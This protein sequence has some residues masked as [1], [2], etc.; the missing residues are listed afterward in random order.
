MRD[1]TLAFAGML[2][3]GELVRQIASSG[4]YSRQAAEA[5]LESIFA[6]DANSAEA[7]YG[8]LAG[9]RMGLQ[10]V[11]QLFSDQRQQEHMPA[12]GY[13]VGLSRIE[14]ELRAQPARLQAMG[15]A[16]DLVEPVRRQAES[17]L[18]DS[19]VA[20]LADV[21]RQHVSVLKF[22]LAIK[23]RAEY[24]QRSDKAALVRALLLA[25]LRSAVLWQQTGGRRWRLV[26]Q[27]RKMLNEAQALLKG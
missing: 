19:V 27:R 22:R 25:G 26:F 10:M 17:L 23:G 9:V 21:Y 13:A 4:Q 6:R 3:V 15:Q 14:Q 1:A 7:V 18:D 20:Q 2:Q 5:S 11:T 24:L 12:L 16:L 8:G